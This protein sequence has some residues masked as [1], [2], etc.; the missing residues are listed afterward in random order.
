MLI[1]VKCQQ[2]LAFTFIRMISTISESPEARKKY[3]F[4]YFRFYKELKFMLR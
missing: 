3:F 1:N 2:L 4:Q